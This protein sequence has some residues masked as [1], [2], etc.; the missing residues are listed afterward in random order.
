MPQQTEMLF[1]GS[2][3]R[4]EMEFNLNCQGRQSGWE[5]ENMSK[6]KMSLD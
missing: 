1:Q 6:E 3:S 5:R 2:N 4:R